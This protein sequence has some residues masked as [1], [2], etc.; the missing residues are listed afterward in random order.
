MMAKGPGFGVFE[1]GSRDI[2]EE[3]RLLFGGREG[4][5]E[6]LGAILGKLSSIGRRRESVGDDEVD[7][8]SEILDEMDPLKDIQERIFG[9]LD[10]IKSIFTDEEIEEVSLTHH[11]SARILFGEIP[12]GDWRR[13]IFFELIRAVEMLDND[14]IANYDGKFRFTLDLL[15][16]EIDAL[17][18]K[19]DADKIDKLQRVEFVY[20]T[21]FDAITD[22][23]YRNTRIA[24]S[25]G[26]T[27]AAKDGISILIRPY[28]DPLSGNSIDVFRDPKTLYVYLRGREAFYKGDG[29]IRAILIY[30]CSEHQIWEIK[31]V[32]NGDEKIENDKDY[33]LWE[34]AEKRAKE[35][36]EKSP[37]AKIFWINKD[38]K[39][40]YIR[41]KNISRLKHI[42]DHMKAIEDYILE[43]VDKFD[44]ENADKVVND[45]RAL[46]EKMTQVCNSIESN[47][48]LHPPY[49]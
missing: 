2:P 13:G 21:I 33:T 12:V 22:I 45:L 11:E 46:R 19:K 24:E 49:K 27:V 36:Q 40:K 6:G 39:V 23:S 3:L 5:P 28:P 34:A 47:I 1:I 9:R 48:S 17:N 43:N 38:G 7:A 41:S 44:I 15:R 37:W 8:F 4:M 30:F 35:I 29:I 32:K 18:K 25:I 42:S 10:I 20:G 31:L 14:K 26:Y 16:K